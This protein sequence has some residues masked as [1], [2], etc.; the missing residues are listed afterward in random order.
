MKIALTIILILVL[1][2]VYILF[3]KVKVHIYFSHG[4]D[5][6]RFQIKIKAFFGLLTKKIDVPVIEVSKKEPAVVIKEK[7]ESNT[8][9]DEKK[10]RITLHDVID[11]FQNTRELIRHIQD[12]YP[13]FKGFLKKIVIL[14]W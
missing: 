14:K 11:S 13:I 4:N 3:S 6:D 2:L 7:T 12:A 9:S 8:S 5:N 1:I 10:K